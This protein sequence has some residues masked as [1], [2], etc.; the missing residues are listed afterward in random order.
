MLEK[1]R[2]NQTTRQKTKQPIRKKNRKNQTTQ[3]KTET[4]N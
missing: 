2:E 4:N 3:Q 1:N